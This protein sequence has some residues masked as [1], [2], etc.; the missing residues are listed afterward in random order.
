MLSS[1]IYKAQWRTVSQRFVFMSTRF[2]VVGHS[3]FVAPRT[4]NFAIWQL[5]RPLWQ[6]HFEK[7]VWQQI[8]QLFEPAS[9][10]LLCLLWLSSTQNCCRSCE[11]KDQ[12]AVDWASSVPGTARTTVANDQSLIHCLCPYQHDPKPTLL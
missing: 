8:C 11:L 2:Y 5:F 1:Y 4:A 12:H 6:L 7:R 9:V 10:T 3:S